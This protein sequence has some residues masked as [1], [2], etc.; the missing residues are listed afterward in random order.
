MWGLVLLKLSRGMYEVFTEQIATVAEMNVFRVEEVAKKKGVSMA[1]VSIAWIISK[2][3]VVAP[4]IGT[5][6]LD[7]LKDMIGKRVFAASGCER[8]NVNYFAGGL[9]VKLTP[10]EIQYLEDPY[11]P[12]WTHGHV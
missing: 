2:D 12:T 3:G 11:R 5:T 7:N 8:S 6:N 1:Q 10:E 4:I 9:D